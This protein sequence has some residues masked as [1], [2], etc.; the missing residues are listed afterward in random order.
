MFKMKEQQ[1]C[2]EVTAERPKQSHVNAQTC[3]L[4][5]NEQFPGIITGIKL[6]SMGKIVHWK[7]FVAFILHTLCKFEIKLEV[8]CFCM[9]PKQHSW[10][11]FGP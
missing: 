11:C 7:N 3:E 4:K 8:V 10:N 9:F 1:V 2:S 6:V 5:L